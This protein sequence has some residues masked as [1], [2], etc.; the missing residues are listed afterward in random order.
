MIVWFSGLT[1]RFP[2]LPDLANQQTAATPKTATL[3][4]R[5]G[6]CC[7]SLLYL[8][9]VKISRVRCSSEWSVGKSE[10][11]YQ[12]SLLACSLSLSLLFR[13]ARTVAHSV[14]SL[15]LNMSDM[16]SDCDDV[17]TDDSKGYNEETKG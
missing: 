7:C 10:T 8:L 1:V 15:F 5:V 14:L 13:R 9:V 17:F 6:V 3:Y 12:H 4:C 2:Q 11:Y 16:D